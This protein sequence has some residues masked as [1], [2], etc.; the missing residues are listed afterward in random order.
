M[1]KILECI[2]VKLLSIVKDEH[3]GDSEVANGTF[4]DEVSDIFL[5]DSGQWFCFDPFGEVV[6]PYDKDLK[7]PYCCGEGSYYV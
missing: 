7:L 4:R 5:R 1:A 3:H 6:N 2:I